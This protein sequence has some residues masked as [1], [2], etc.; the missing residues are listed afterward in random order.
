MSPLKPTKITPKKVSI[1][2]IYPYK[3]ERKKK[4]FFFLKI[5]KSKK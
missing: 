4:D 1:R 5:K 3:F 2:Q